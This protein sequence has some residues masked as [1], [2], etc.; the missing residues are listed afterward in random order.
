M[1]HRIR[2][3]M[4]EEFPTKLSEVVEVDETYIGGKAKHSE[5]SSLI[6]EKPDKNGVVADCQAAL[7]SMTSFPPLPSVDSSRSLRSK[8]L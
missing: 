5:F 8:I 1:V 3:A 7:Q 2:K 6:L 4:V